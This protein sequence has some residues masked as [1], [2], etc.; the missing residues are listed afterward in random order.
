[1]GKSLFRY[2]ALFCAVIMLLSVGG[3]W[4]I[5]EYAS[6]SPQDAQISISVSVNNFVYKPDL[7]EGEVSFLERLN[8]IL[9]NNFSNDIIPEN[10]SMAYLLSTLDKDWDS[11][12]NPAIGSFVGSMDPTNE[13][14]QR[15]DTMFG[16]LIELDNVSFIIKSE[17]L[18]GSVADEIAIYSTLDPLDWS[19]SHGITSVVGVYLTVFVPIH[20]ETGAII[21]YEQLC[22]SVHGYCVEV[23]YM[24]GD[25]TP[26]FSTDH[27]RDELFYWNENYPNPVP[28]TGEDRYKYE[29]YHT[30]DGNYAYPGRTQ[31][32]LGWI[33]VQTN[34]WYTDEYTG[35]KASQVLN[36]ILAEKS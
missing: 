23:Q 19:P 17:D 3:V 28:I 27:W 36:E 7:P 11:G 15:I 35:K 8:D 34:Q 12:V 6:G 32:W 21:G 20:D 16:D 1:M 30:S 31:S 14:R 5:W 29:C 18:V 10:Q 25:N 4:A 13:S 33:N 24:D 2:V 9:N 26:S 22:D